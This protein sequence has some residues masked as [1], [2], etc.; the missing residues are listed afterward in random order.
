MVVTAHDTEKTP[1][2]VSVQNNGNKLV[3]VTVHDTE[4]RAELPYLVRQN[5]PQVHIGPGKR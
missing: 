4:N 2:F 1:V 3:F 5:N